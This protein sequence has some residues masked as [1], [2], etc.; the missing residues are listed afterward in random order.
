[1]LDEVD[2]DVDELMNVWSVWDVGFSYFDSQILSN[3]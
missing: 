3:F 1:L 2:L